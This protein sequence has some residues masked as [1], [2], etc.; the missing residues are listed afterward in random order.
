MKA[1]YE[2]LIANS[3]RP[4]QLGLMVE[5]L[6]PGATVVTAEE[7]AARSDIA[8]LAL[9]LGKYRGIPVE[10]LAGT[11]VIDA[12]NYWPEID[13]IIAEFEQDTRSSSE[14][15]QDFLPRPG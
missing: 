7:A 11:I 1:G 4:G 2:V 8:Y 10:K 15:I 14:L 12:M 5:V 6:M 13:G 3:P 9:P